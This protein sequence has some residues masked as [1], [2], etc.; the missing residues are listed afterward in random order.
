MIF[1]TERLIIRDYRHED[2]AVFFT[3]AGKPEVRL[4]H[5]RVVT[6]AECDAFIDA[7]IETIRDLGCGYAVVERKADGAVVGDVGIRPV[8]DDIPISGGVDFEI[9][10]QLDPRYFGRGWF[11]SPSRL[12]RQVPV[13]G[14]SR[15]ADTRGAAHRGRMEPV[16]HRRSGDGR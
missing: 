10:W 9:G 14:P 1:E 2:R 11:P 12:S 6:R 5:T 7:Q 16:R 4:F 13:S 8:P 15:S 3:I